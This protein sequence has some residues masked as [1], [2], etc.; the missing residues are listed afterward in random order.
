MSA[1]IE[2]I[3]VAGDRAAELATRIKYAGMDSGRISI[4]RDY[5]K[6]VE[7]ADAQDTPVFMMPTYTSMLE[8]R[9][10]VIRH[11]GGDDFWV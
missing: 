3:V 2:N 5:R 10:A 6:L 11:C 8:L 7:W 4:E 1:W 9:E